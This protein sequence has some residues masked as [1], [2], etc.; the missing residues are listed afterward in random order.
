ML[1][2]CEGG[3][4]LGSCTGLTVLDY[5]D[6]CFREELR[7]S[8]PIN[9]ARAHRRYCLR[10]RARCCG[11]LRELGIASGAPVAGMDCAVGMSASCRVSAPRVMWSWLPGTASPTA[12]MRVRRA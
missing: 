12:S 10:C 2:V 3:H 6:T 7:R 4:E 11:G 9:Q 1:E 5:S 8:D